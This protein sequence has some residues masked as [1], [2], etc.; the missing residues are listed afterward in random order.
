[1]IS[2]TILLIILIG[3]LLGCICEN[4]FRVTRCELNSPRLSFSVASFEENKRLFR[5]PMRYGLGWCNP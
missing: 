4:V 3:S 1:V 2:L 5:M